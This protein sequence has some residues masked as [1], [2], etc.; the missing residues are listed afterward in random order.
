MRMDRSYSKAAVSRPT[1]RS[2]SGSRKDTEAKGVRDG[3]K[4]PEDSSGEAR[5]WDSWEGIPYYSTPEQGQGIK[6]LARCSVTEAHSYSWIGLI[7]FVVRYDSLTHL[8]AYA[9]ITLQCCRCMILMQSR[10]QRVKC[11]RQ[12]SPD[13]AA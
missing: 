5:N 13:S 1:E 10:R 6:D 9:C 8:A 3:E 2:S 11:A 4:E 7:D 12:R